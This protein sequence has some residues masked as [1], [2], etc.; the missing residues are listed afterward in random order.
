MPCCSVCVNVHSHRTWSTRCRDGSDDV[1]DCCYQRPIWQYMASGSGASNIS[2]AGVPAVLSSG[3]TFNYSLS[4]SGTF[5]FNVRVLSLPVFGSTFSVVVRSSAGLPTA[6]NSAVGVIQ[7]SCALLGIEFNFSVWHY[8]HW[9]YRFF[10]QMR[11]SAIK[12]CFCHAIIRCPE[13]LFALSLVA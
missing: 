3:T 12:C 2:I 9:W 8:F 1:L 10:R 6:A 4:S 13:A 5:Q 11:S 7:C